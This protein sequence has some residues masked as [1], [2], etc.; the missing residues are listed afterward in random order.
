MQDL[1]VQVQYDQQLGRDF[2]L[3]LLKERFDAVFVGIGLPQ[4][5]RPA[6][7]DGLDESCGFFT[8]KDFL[9]KVAVGSKPGMCACKAAA[10]PLPTLSG[11]SSGVCFDRKSF[12]FEF[13]S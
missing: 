5:K 1:G 3:T 12:G 11:W 4:A 2:S 9:P 7:F 13:K 6:L 10:S 8:S